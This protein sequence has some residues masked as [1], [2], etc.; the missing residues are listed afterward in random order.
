MDSGECFFLI[1]NETN[2]KNEQISDSR[3]MV[4]VC[5]NKIVLQFYQA[6]RCRFAMMI[7]EV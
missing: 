6:R 4:G 1:Q 3:G 2:G 7:T 5:K